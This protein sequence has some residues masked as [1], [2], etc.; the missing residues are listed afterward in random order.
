[1]NTN[2]FGQLFHRMMKDSHVF[3]FKK[4]IHLISMIWTWC[5]GE[6]EALISTAGVWGL[7]FSTSQSQ[8]HKLK[9]NGTHVLIHMA[10]KQ[11]YS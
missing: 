4:T 1:M 9:Q 8:L 7:W 11:L 5:L 2:I 10:Q 6:A 3:I